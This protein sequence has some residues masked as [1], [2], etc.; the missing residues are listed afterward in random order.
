[1]CADQELELKPER[2]IGADIPAIVEVVLHANF[3]EFRRIHGEVWRHGSLVDP[4]RRCECRIVSVRPVTPKPGDD[5]RPD[6]PQYLRIRATILQSLVRQLHGRI[7]CRY[8]S[9]S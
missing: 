5:S 7:V 8:A 6:A 9:F 1:M 4:K 2:M 3:R